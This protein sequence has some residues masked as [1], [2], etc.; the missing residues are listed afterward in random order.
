[1]RRHVQS[2]Q[3]AIPFDGPL[4]APDARHVIKPAV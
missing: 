4:V 1:M 3:F 2:Q